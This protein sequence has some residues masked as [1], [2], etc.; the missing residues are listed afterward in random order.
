MRLLLSATGW[1]RSRY[2]IP[3]FVYVRRRQY[4]LLQNVHCHVSGNASHGTQQH[5]GALHLSPQSHVRDRRSSRQKAIVA[6]GHPNLRSQSN[7]GGGGGGCFARF[8]KEAAA[9]ITRKTVAVPFSG[10][11]LCRLR[12]QSALATS[13]GTFLD[14]TTLA[15]LAADHQ[16]VAHGRR[17]RRSPQ[18]ALSLVPDRLVPVLRHRLDARRRQPRRTVLRGL[19]AATERRGRRGRPPAVAAARPDAALSRVS[20]GH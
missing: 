16:Q 1:T 5:S 19:P 14:A 20:D 9:A 10:L 4:K 3:P 12:F 18:R 17:R 8:Q 15:I 2:R 7:L 13:S 6:N 11:R